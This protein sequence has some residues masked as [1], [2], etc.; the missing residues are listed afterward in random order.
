MTTLINKEKMIINEGRNSFSVVD[1]FP[2]K[3]IVWNIGRHNF[4]HKC[5]VPLAFIDTSWG[6]E[7]HIDPNNLM[8]IKVDS[9][10]KALQIIEAAHHRTINKEAFI[11]L[12]Q[13]N[14]NDL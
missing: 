9:E 4:R 8:A 12:M 1:V 7:F 14:N 10:Q 13:Q 5:Y 11:Q 3:A 2:E 6:D